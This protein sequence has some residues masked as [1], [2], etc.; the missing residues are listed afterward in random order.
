MRMLIQLVNCY[1]ARRN[2][3]N[4]FCLAFA[5][6]IDDVLRKKL[7]DGEDAAVADRCIRAEEYCASYQQ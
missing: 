2:G 3:L 1:L 7:S 6:D 4:A 5:D